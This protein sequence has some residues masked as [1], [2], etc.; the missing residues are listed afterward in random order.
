MVCHWIDCDTGGGDVCGDS[1]EGLRERVGRGDRGRGHEGRREEDTALY[2][3]EALASFLPGVT[4]AVSKLLTSTT[5]LGQVTCHLH[6]VSSFTP[7]S[8]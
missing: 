4:I 1:L 7:L 5:N 2:V 8:S 6:N 3:G